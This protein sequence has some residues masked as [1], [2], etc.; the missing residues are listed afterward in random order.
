MWLTDAEDVFSCSTVGSVERGR[1]PT[2]LE[3]GKTKLCHV[4]TACLITHLDRG[5]G[6]RLVVFTP[7]MMY[8]LPWKPAVSQVRLFSFHSVNHHARYGKVIGAACV[9]TLKG[10]MQWRS[11]TRAHRGPGSGEFLSALVNHGRS[12][13]LNRNNIA[14][15]GIVV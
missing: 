14:L 4:L 7:S 8:V 6:T 1:S 12:T 5:L 10:S 11:Y 13:Y 9:D 2:N 3:Q 15:Y